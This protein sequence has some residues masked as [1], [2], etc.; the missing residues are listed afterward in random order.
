MMITG[1]TA[2]LLLVLV[3]ALVGQNWGASG[4]QGTEGPTPWAH[5][6]SASGELTAAGVWTPGPCTHGGSPD[7]GWGDRILDLWRCGWG[8]ELL[9]L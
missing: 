3:L 2:L 9:V 7:S 1:V 4:T 5:T 6:T 8:L